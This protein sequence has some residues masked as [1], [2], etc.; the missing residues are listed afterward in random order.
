M[1]CVTSFHKDH[2]DIYANRFIKAWAQHWPESAKLYLYHQKCKVDHDRIINIDLDS[3]VNFALF[4]NRTQELIDQETNKKTINKYLKGLRWSHKVYSICDLLDNTD[5]PIIWLDA[6]T[7]TTKQIPQGY[8][9]LLLQGYDLAVHIETQNKMVHWESG[10][11][12]IAGTPEQR[13]VLKHAMLDIYDN[14][15]IWDKPKSWD[16]HL[17]PECATHMKCNDLNKDIKGSRKGY[18]QNKNVKPYMVHI[19]GDKKF[20]GNINKRSGRLSS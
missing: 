11:F 8:D 4:K 12:V 5:E 17:W 18:F 7:V 19:A 15:L 16:G 13:Q 2:W 3:Q 10:L 9:Q 6:D 14:H 1:I 20:T